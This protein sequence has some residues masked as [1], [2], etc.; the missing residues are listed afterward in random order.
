ML[1]AGEWDDLVAVL[2]D[3]I[4]GETMG[5]DP[6]ELLDAYL[7]WCDQEGLDCWDA[8]TVDYWASGATNT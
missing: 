8:G 6:G 1:F 3:A 5:M 2:L 7:E 4:D